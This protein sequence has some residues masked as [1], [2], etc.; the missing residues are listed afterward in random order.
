MAGPQREEKKPRGI[1]NANIA[2]RIPNAK[3][4][5]FLDQSDIAGAR[6][7]AALAAGHRPEDYGYDPETRKEIV[8]PDLT[9]AQAQQVRMAEA[10]RVRQSRMLASKPQAAPAAAGTPDSFPLSPL[11]RPTPTTPD[12]PPDRGMIDGKPAGL[13]LREMREKNEAK[14]PTELQFSPTRAEREYTEWEARVK[15]DKEAAAA[16][17]AAS[18]KSA[19]EAKPKPKPEPEGK[20]S[21][22]P[23]E[24]KTDTADKP[25][26]PRDKPGGPSSKPN[27]PTSQEEDE[28]PAPVVAGGAV[29]TWGSTPLSIASKMGMG[30]ET[31]F[32]RSGGRLSKVGDAV[33][34]EA[35]V[36][37][38][39]AQGA[40][41]RVG[42]LQG[43]AEVVAEK[44]AKVADKINDSRKLLVESLKEGARLNPATTPPR[45]M[46]SA[47]ETPAEIIKSIKALKDR[48]GEV[49]AVEGKV[50]S[51]LAKASEEAA[52]KTL[53]YN[54]VNEKAASILGKA[55]KYAKY[56][57]VLRKAALP[58]DVALNVIEGFRLASS[59]Q[60]RADRVK[61]FEEYADKGVVQSTL[62]SVLNPVAGIYSTAHQ[63]NERSKSV[64]AAKASGQAA[65]EAQSQ[66][67]R[68][69]NIMD[70]EGVT[71]ESLR[72]LTQSERSAIMKRIREQAR[73]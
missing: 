9:A 10:E 8:K 32:R 2:S 48:A 24:K 60:H 28:E 5:E 37:H 66:Q 70:A 18:K 14:I 59:E 54:K 47:R 15:A 34:G 53:K 58:V 13:A 29:D 68:R 67:A 23:A 31:F 26:P 20:A 72:A 51:S 25:E 62:Q 71:R 56:G 4:R 46:Q 33:A 64:A 42:S 65:Q 1:S 6:W 27:S 17:A 39:T 40:L 69:Q 49:A 35:K 63:L 52:A 57:K 12:K 22:K 55:T 19:S 3:D 44:A 45:V 61:E 21:P 30:A 16:A 11:L 43:R 41:K 38:D 50:T 73:K 7:A 36:L